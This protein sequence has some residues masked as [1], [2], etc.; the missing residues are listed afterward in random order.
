MKQANI[1]SLD[2]IIADAGVY[3]RTWVA[4]HWWC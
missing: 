1:F 2:I 4:D 3:D